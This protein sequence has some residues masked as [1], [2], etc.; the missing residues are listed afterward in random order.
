MTSEYQVRQVEKSLRLFINIPSCSL[1]GVPGGNVHILGG[2][3]I[4]KSKQTKNV[5]MY[6][7]PIPSGF[8]N[9]AISLNGSLDL[10]PNTVLHSRR[11]APRYFFFMGLYDE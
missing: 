7:R 11:T 5:Y 10:A 6:T 2:H 4:G 9:R 3:S 8:R 1:Q